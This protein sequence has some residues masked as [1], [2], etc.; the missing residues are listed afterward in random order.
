MMYLLAS[1]MV[2]M[3]FGLITVFLYGPENIPSW[4]HL[5]V[6]AIIGAGGAIRLLELMAKTLCRHR[7]RRAK[8]CRI[9]GFEHAS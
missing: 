8:I 4:S 3:L 6:W 9:F 2:A 1:I 5:G 7:I